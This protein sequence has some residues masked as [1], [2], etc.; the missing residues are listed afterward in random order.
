MFGCL[1]REGDAFD[2]LQTCKVISETHEDQAV[3][4]RNGIIKTLTLKK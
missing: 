2:E 4:G 3:F 1:D